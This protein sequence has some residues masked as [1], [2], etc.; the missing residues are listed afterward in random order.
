MDGDWQATWHPETETA[1]V[2][3]LM[4]ERSPN[5]PEGEYRGEW[6]ILD[7]RYT[8]FEPYQVLMLDLRISPPEPHCEAYLE[9]HSGDRFPRKDSRT[10][11]QAVIWLPW[12]RPRTRSCATWRNATT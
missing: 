7:Y 10:G 6:T 5:W 8:G 4:V 2:V 3:R 9:F 1:R 11:R 12:S